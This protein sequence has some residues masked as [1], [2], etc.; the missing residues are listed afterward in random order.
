[1]GRYASLVYAVVY[2]CAACG[3]DS[4]GGPADAPVDVAVADAR[5]DARADAPAACL[6]DSRLG[7]ACTNGVGG[8]ARTGQYV[9]TANMVTV[10][11]DAVAG[12][13]AA[14][15]CADI[16]VDEDCDGD[17]SDVDGLGADCATTMMGAC[18]AGRTACQGTTIGCVAL[19][20]PTD[21][22]CSNLGTDDDCDGPSTDLEVAEASHLLLS[23]IV[24]RPTGGEAIEIYNPTLATITL[25]S[26]ALADFSTYWAAPTGPY[27]TRAAGSDFIVRFPA[28]STIPACARLVVSIGRADDYLTV[29]GALP[30]FEILT[31]GQIGTA[32]DNAATPNML[33]SLGATVPSTRGLS[34]ESEMVALFRLETNG[35]TDVD[36]VSWGTQE[37]ERVD[38]TGVPG[39][40]RDTAPADQDIPA[41]P[42]GAQSLS[43]CT[44]GETGELAQDGNGVDA[45][46]E[47][48]ERMTRSW[49]VTAG[50]TP[51]SPDAT[52]V[53]VLCSGLSEI[54]M[55]CTSSYGVCEA[56]G[57]YTCGPS[58]ANLLCNG[59]PLASGPETCVDVGVDNDCDADVAD[60]DG[61]GDACGAG[62]ATNVCNASNVLECRYPRDHLI[63]T[64]VVARPS[65]DEAIEILNPT[66][67]AISLTNVGLADTN[68]Y[69]TLDGT[70]TTDFIVRFPDGASIPA[71]GRIVVSTYGTYAGQTADYEILSTTETGQPATDNAAVPNMVHVDV[72]GDPALA[73]AAEMVV[74]FQI[75][76]G[77]AHKDLD[78]VVWGTD[79]SVRVDKTAVSGFAPDTAVSSQATLGT[80]HA[81]G[82]SFHRC[83][84]GEGAET[85]TAGNGVTGHDETSEDFTQTWHTSLADTLGEDDPS[86]P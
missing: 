79:I 27:P 28:G 54:G 4:A 6:S 43:R 2:V 1:M 3:D 18:Q 33:G 41:A 10:E 44:P 59:V 80:V 45:H 70:V 22:T 30:D 35:V 26:Y 84:N 56:S 63:I 81:V 9:C 60:V 52:C 14:E 16:G 69:Y 74:L 72:T 21:E 12:E 67:S 64:E 38:K 24:T 34:D 13:G 73:D 49:K 78:Y 7:T 31:P 62:C 83:A 37:A 17:D 57:M 82:E 85:A 20:T 8:C 47:T 5:A 29:R 36:Y 39:F 51:G 40:V 25:T 86:C 77:G 19:F 76:A 42:T 75:D 50:A 48:S 68:V 15:T 23:E 32:Q 55:S 71:C 11:C 65:A 58:G 66:S 46:D 61:L 53:P